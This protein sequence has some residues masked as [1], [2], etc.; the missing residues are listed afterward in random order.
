VSGWTQ[1]ESDGLAT[2]LPSGPRPRPFRFSAGN[3]RFPDCLLS[4]SVALP[5]LAAGRGSAICGGGCVLFYTDSHRPWA[6]P[7]KT[8]RPY[9]NNT[10]LQAGA[11]G[12]DTIFSGQFPT[13]CA[14]AFIP[15]HISISTETAMGTSFETPV[16]RTRHSSHLQL[17]GGAKPI[18]SAAARS[19]HRMSRIT[20]HKVHIRAR[21]RGFVIVHTSRGGNQRTASRME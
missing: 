3:Y 13:I 7:P 21:N 18:R 19:S 2:G 15:I 1:R 12:S 20:R 17:G 9:C 11:A 6:H 14:G 5:F 4:F 8:T 10:G 16:C